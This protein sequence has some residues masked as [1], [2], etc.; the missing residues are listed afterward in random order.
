MALYVLE[1]DH[2]NDRQYDCLT[3]RHLTT[4]PGLACLAV[5]VAPSCTSL[6]T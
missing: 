2:G 3:F 5:S 1:D 4:A 6:L